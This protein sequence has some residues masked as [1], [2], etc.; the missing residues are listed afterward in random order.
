MLVNKTPKFD[1]KIAGE[2]T[3]YTWA[4]CKSLY[5]R[6]P[7]AKKRGRSTFKQLVKDCT[8]HAQVGK[9]RADRFAAR[10]R[11]YMC[12]YYI[13][14]VEKKKMDGETKEVVD[15]VEEEEEV[16]GGEIGQAQFGQIAQLAKGFRS[17]LSA[18]HFDSKFVQAEIHSFNKE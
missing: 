2:G 4:F 5:R 3:K 12:A 6:I 18:M 1:A 11:A 15:L 17:H 10:A 9:Y 14:D 7:W 8:E 13:L 16:A